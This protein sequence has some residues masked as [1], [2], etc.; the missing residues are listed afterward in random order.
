MADAINPIDASLGECLAK[1]ENS[2]TAGM[3][4]CVHEANALWEQETISIYRKLANHLTGEPKRNLELSQKAWIAFR[5]AESKAAE[6]IFSNVQGTMYTNIQAIGNL[7]ITKARALA[8]NSYA[9]AV[10]I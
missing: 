2:T 3:N 4:T 1:K 6:S 9:R 5:D 7:N 10:G 8:L